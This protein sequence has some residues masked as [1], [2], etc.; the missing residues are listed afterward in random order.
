[1][2]SAWGA[3]CGV[4]NTQL[5][6][7][8]RLIRT[9]VCRTSKVLQ[10]FWSTF[11]V[12]WKWWSTFEVLWSTLK[13]FEV[14]WKYDMVRTPPLRLPPPVSPCQPP[15]TFTR[16]HTA[17]KNTEQPST[18][19]P[20]TPFD[21]SLSLALVSLWHWHRHHDNNDD[22]NNNNDNNN[23]NNNNNYYYYYY[24]YNHHYNLIIT[25]TRTRMTR[26]TTTAI[27]TSYLSP[28][29][30]GCKTT[31]NLRLITTAHYN[32]INRWRRHQ[33]RNWHYLQQSSHLHFPGWIGVKLSLIWLGV[34]RATRLYNNKPN[35]FGGGG[36]GW[37]HGIAS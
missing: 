36:R 25:H 27:T 12:L 37:T 21:S 13:Y 8:W 30:E 18:K 7:F 23:N 35:F 28:S 15:P 2:T 3:R 19:W 32:N 9:Y 6:L 33:R 17:I 31:I 14:L 5:A 24:Y 26:T 10:K 1:M 16:T 34:L 20:D 22:G 11:E 4:Q 29:F